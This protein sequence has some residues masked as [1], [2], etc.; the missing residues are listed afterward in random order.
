VAAASR[1]CIT[2]AVVRYPFLSFSDLEAF[3][4]DHISETISGST[5][6]LTF[7]SQRFAG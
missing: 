3:R 5:G 2:D 7:F 4:A 1:D 6:A